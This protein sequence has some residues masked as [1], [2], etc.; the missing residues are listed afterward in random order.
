[1]ARPGRARGSSHDAR[2]HRAAGRARASTASTSTARSTRAAQLENAAAYLELHIEQGP[3]SSRW[4]SRSASCSAPSASSARFHLARPGRARRLD[5]DGQ[6][7]RRARRRREARARDPRRSRGDVG[8]GAVCTSGGVVCKPGIVTSVVETAEQLLDQRHLDAATLARMLDAA[9][10][11]SRALRRG[12]EHRRRVGADLEH[13]ADP[14]RRDADRA[15]RRGD[16]RGRAARRTGCRAGRCTT[17]PRSRA[18]A[19]RR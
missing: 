14:V 8:G 19:S 9:Q 18:R 5:A 4:T 2:R 15:R 6:A 7:P 11:A 17:P 12:G 3:C 16:P 10:E 1:M 13:R